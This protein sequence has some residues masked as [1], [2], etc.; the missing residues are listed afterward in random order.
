MYAAVGGGGGECKP[1]GKGNA[2]GAGGGGVSLGLTEGAPSV[3]G[4]GA[5]TKAPPL[6]SV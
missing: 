2:V 3:G 4:R 6:T 5:R 1:V